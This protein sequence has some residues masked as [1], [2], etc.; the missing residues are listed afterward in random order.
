MKPKLKIAALLILLGCV[1]QNSLF[2]NP[3]NSADVN[4]QTVTV[5][6]T[7]TDVN[8][9]E[10]L[11]GVSIQVNGT[12]RG[13]ITDANGKYVIEV[14]TGDVLVFSYVGYLQEQ[15]A[16]GDQSVINM[17]MAEDIIGLDELIVIGYGT[18]KKSDLTGAVASISVDD[19]QKIPN[20]GVSSMLQG[21]AA[22]VQV[23][24]NSGQPG[25][26]PIIRVRGL[27]TVN[28]GAPL[29]VI[30]GISGGSLADLNPADVASIEVLKDAASQGI[31]GSAG[32]NGVILVTTKKGTKG[33]LKV[34]FDQYTGVQ[35]PWKTT[36]DAVNAQEY[37]ELYNVYKEYKGLEAYFP[38][39]NGQ[40]MNP[41]DTPATV[42]ESTDW[43]KEIFRT[44]LVNNTNLSISGG[45]D[46]GNVFLGLNYNLEQGTLLKTDAEKYV[47]RLNSE[48]HLLKKR[49]TIGENFNLAQAGSSNQFE[50]NEYGSPLATSLQMFPFIPVY[51]EDGSGNFA[52]RGAGLSCNIA[53]PMSQ[54]EY[55][56]S[57]ARSTSVNA[58]A[59]IRLEILKGLTFESRYGFGYNPTSYRQYSPSYQIGELDNISPSMSSPFHQYQY[60]VTLSNSWQWQNFFNY[61]FSLANTHNFALTAGYEAGYSRYEFTNRQ[62]SYD[63]VYFALEDWESYADADTM[64]ILQTKMTETTGYAYFFRVGYDY[65][66]I[67]LMQANLRR[68]ASS[69]IGPN[70][71]VGVFPSYSIGLKFSELGFIKDLGIFDLGKIR[72]GYGETGNSDIQP[73]QYLGTIASL[74]MHGYPL[75]GTNTIPG[76]GLI[77]ASNLDLRWETVVTSN[78]GVDMSFMQNRISLSFDLFKRRNQDMLLRKSVPTAVGYYVTDANNELGDSQIDTRPLQNYGT[79]NNRGFEI[80]ASYKDNA[81]ALHYEISGNITRA[82]T[83]IDDI[84]DPLTNF[85]DGRG[86][87]DVCQTHNGGAVSAFYGYQTDGVYTEEDFVWLQAENGR[88]RQIAV[89]ENGATTFEGRDINGDPIIVNSTAP[90]ARPGDFRY[91]DLNQDGAIN[92]LDYTAIGN[93]NPDFTFGLG[94]YLEYHNFDLNMLWQ[95]SYGNDIFNLMK[96]NSYNIENGNLNISTGLQEAY[97]PAVYEA[98][99]ATTPPT[100]LIDEQNVNTGIKRMD[101]P[102]SQCDFFIEDGSYLRLKNLQVGYNFPVAS[103]E[104]IGLQ[105]LRVY[106]NT[107]NLLTFTNYTGFDPEVNETS[108]LERGFDR[109]TYPQPRMVT[110][111]INCIF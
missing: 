72:V 42:L 20:T 35:Y 16:V 109:G 80:T 89:D 21:M 33:K 105:K 27:A 28:G 110:L 46:V 10:A 85:G 101:G 67:L 83:T 78:L 38:Y 25:S 70:N 17:A 81:G 56:N 59:F 86:V 92:S 7:V 93:P 4:Q 108:L 3:P 90:S 43:V 26:E 50:R 100:V 52:Y 102:L 49:V 2:G 75:D 73:F 14:S 31:Y 69:K 57:R 12:T 96:V 103:M 30:D 79:L 62:N 22:G 97:I 23:L 11:P 15:V 68:D 37:A 99:T 6:G 5:T 58:N 41:L 48:L 19:M 53:N 64:S 47:I 44:A 13:T 77:T 54:L 61:N 9:G 111:G 34:N 98:G 36:S 24:Q 107:L 39:E 106:V 66:G 18:Q 94:I 88:W 95:G 63:T 55:R 65:K 45:S 29:V 74:P 51:A 104:K 1:L 60:N 87:G 32:G 76:A 71:R 82:I 8:S 40:Y 91:M 84:G